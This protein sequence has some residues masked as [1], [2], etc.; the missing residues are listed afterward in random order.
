MARKSS[1]TAFQ[2]ELYPLPNGSREHD[3][4]ERDAPVREPFDDSR[5]VTVSVQLDYLGLEYEDAQ[6]TL[7]MGQALIVDL[8][9]AWHALPV[10]DVYAAVENLFNT[11]YLVGRAGVDTVGQPLFVHGGVRI[12]LGE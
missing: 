9:A 5:L 6:N 7:P 1:S 2:E 3:A 10:L 8:F 4:S 11:Q 12:H